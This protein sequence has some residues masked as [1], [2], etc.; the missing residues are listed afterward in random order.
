[1]STSGA[2]AGAPHEPC[3]SL[4]SFGNPKGNPRENVPSFFIVGHTPARVSEGWLRPDDVYHPRLCPSMSSKWICEASAAFDASQVLQPSLGDVGVETSGA[5][6]FDAG[7]HPAGTVRSLEKFMERESSSPWR[8]EER[9]RNLSW[10]LVPSMWRNSPGR[11]G[12]NCQLGSICK[13]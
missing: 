1:M 13:R 8:S 4:F 9:S 5:G 12:S 10:P 2:Q 11:T 7:V 3:E 6:N